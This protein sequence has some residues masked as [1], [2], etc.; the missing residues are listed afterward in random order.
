MPSGKAILGYG[1]IAFGVLIVLI[2]IAKY[3][4]PACP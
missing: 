1:F 4:R 2:C 3:L